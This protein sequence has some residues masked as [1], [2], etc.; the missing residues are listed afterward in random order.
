MQS[1]AIYSNKRLFISLSPLKN[2]T[3]KLNQ[4]IGNFTPVSQSTWLD[5]RLFILT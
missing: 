2:T 1:M 4:I 5:E 3:D